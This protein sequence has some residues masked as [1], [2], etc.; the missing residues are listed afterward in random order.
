[1]FVRHMGQLSSEQKVTVK[2]IF[3]KFVGEVVQ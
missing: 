1:M 3:I 2:N